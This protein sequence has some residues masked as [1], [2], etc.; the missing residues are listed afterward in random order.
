MKKIKT[1]IFLLLLVVIVVL[2]YQLVKMLI[3]QGHVNF[4]GGETSV[5]SEETKEEKSESE[6]Q[7]KEAEKTKT[8]E[9]K[10]ETTENKTGTSTAAEAGDAVGEKTVIDENGT[11]IAIT[12]ITENVGSEMIVI[13]FAGEEN[14]AIEAP[15]D[16]IMKYVDTQGTNVVY[17]SLTLEPV[18]LNTSYGE[19]VLHGITTL[20]GMATFKGN[21]EYE[22]SDTDIG[23]SGTIRIEGS[24]ASFT[25]TN[26]AVSFVQVG[27]QFVFTKAFQ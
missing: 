17:S 15:T 18:D 11:E 24:S 26:T 1:V 21:G 10:T 16:N 25:V 9:E 6:T 14:G 19:I 3:D 27:D 12:E 8:T 5:T 2:G 13:D 7:G 4:S 20:N 22:F 23:I